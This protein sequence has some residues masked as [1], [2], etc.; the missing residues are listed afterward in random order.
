MKIT[1]ISSLYN[2]ND[3]IN[4]Y[5]KCLSELNDLKNNKLIIWN[6]YDSNTD[7]T[8]QKIE[9]FCK[10][11]DYVKLI[12]KTKSEDTGLY[13]S[14]NTMFKLVDTD[15]VCNY[16]TDDKLHPDF[17]NNTISNFN[18]YNEMDI[19]IFPSYITENFN[20]NFNDNKKLN[21]I[22]TKLQFPLNNNFEETYLNHKINGVKLNLE[23]K[24][25]DKSIKLSIY[26]VFRFKNK[27]PVLFNIFGCCPIFKIKLLDKFG[28]INEQDYGPSADCEFW[29]R[30]IKN[31]VNVRLFN[32]PLSIYYINP[33]SYSRMNIKKAVY[34]MKIINNYNPYKELDTIYTTKYINIINTPNKIKKKKIKNKY[35]YYYDKDWQYP[36]ITEYQSFKL[37]FN[38]DI[39]PC[40]YFAFPWATL[41]DQY[42]KN[43]NT[44]L[45]ECIGNF[46]IDNH[47][48]CFTICQHIRFRFLFPILKAIG[49]THLFASH[50]SKYDYLYE[51]KF[52]IK[53]IPFHLFPYN[54]INNYNLS[55]KK[56]TYKVSFNGSYNKKYYLKSR[57]YLNNQNNKNIFINIKDNWHFEKIVYQEQINKI[58]LNDDE[59]K[60]NTN[61]ESNYLKLLEKS[62]FS[63]CPSGT[64]P[65]SI[66]LWESLSVGSIPIILSDNLKLYEQ[67]Q[68]ENYVIFWKE[69]KYSELYDY[70]NNIPIHRI[71]LMQ[72]NCI[73]L[74]N[75]YFCKENFINIIFE[76]FKNYNGKILLINNDYEAHYECVES[77]ILK[78]QT[79]TN[80][81]VDK[82][83][84][85][86]KIDSNW[87]FGNKNKYDFIS[88]IKDKYP[89]ISFLKP[90]CY[91]YFIENT[92]NFE[93]NYTNKNFHYYLSHRNFDKFLK[94]KNIILFKNFSCDILPFSNTFKINKNVPIYLLSGDLARKNINKIIKI[95]NLECNYEFKINIICRSTSEN[96]KIIEDLKNLKYFNRCIINLE[97][98]FIEFHKNINGS[99]CQ[100]FFL[101]END[102]EYFNG[103]KYSGCLG[104]TK[105]YNLYSF[106][107]TKLN[108]FYKLNKVFEY[109]NYNFENKFIESILYFYNT[110]KILTNLSDLLKNNNINQI[111]ISKGIDKNIKLPKLSNKYDINAPILFFGMY[112]FKDF[113]KFNK[114]KGKKYIVWCD[115]DCDINNKLR[116]KLIYKI[117]NYISSNYYF[118]DNCKK[119]LD[120]LKINSEKIL[121]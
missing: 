41:I 116:T 5:I 42:V 99:Y 62:N 33:N 10:N 115:K 20:Y 119:N 19:C 30:L 71:K 38:N 18:K 3:Y 89:N 101:N 121:L 57:S 40:N 36:V 64:G 51:N 104:I 37:F 17:L 15:L 25:Y 23:W 9:N 81:E 75:S 35:I 11:K 50:T 79:I 95:L 4:N 85:N 59:I 114:H 82:I 46:K 67:I 94:F 43:K 108:K 105:A 83:Y 68:W 39:I 86:L 93:K 80:I 58:K 24:T 120:F 69:N 77:L 60:N 97:K 2:C 92:L 26:N 91:N 29:M 6:I 78:Y 61:L 55:N 96:I 103:I 102:D 13:D 112:F 87:D 70:I 47:N 100:L 53:I 113:T 48:E 76:Y 1:L 98:T 27:N 74:F 21:T 54:S 117:K 28:Y 14:W 65:N 111:N 52:N 72:Q 22:Y 34:D 56:T 16:N 107:D 44:Y 45:I 32:K 90:L 110:I 7:E 88:Y 31:N 49:I 66:R 106:I 8:N 12:K 63:L 118:Y 109:D 84:I 73:N